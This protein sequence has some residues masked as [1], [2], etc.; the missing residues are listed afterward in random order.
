MRLTEFIKLLDSGVKRYYMTGD[1]SAGVLA[2]LDMEGRLF[3]VLNGKVV[4]RVNREAA[5]GQSTAESYLN[6]GGDTLWPAPEGTCLGYEYSSGK[7]R[8]PPA[9]TG[10]RYVV[11]RKAKNS[12]VI[13]AEIDLVNN[14]GIGLPFI[15]ERAVKVSAG[16]NSVTV[17][18]V[19]SIKYIGVKSYSKKDFMIAPW[20][21]SQF[22]SGEG[23]EAVFPGAEDT[24]IRDLYEP[25]DKVRRHAGGLWRFRTDGSAK[26]QIAIGAE[27][28]WIEFKNPAK[29]LTV[30][31]SASPV[32]G[33]M[34]YIDI[35]DAPPDTAPAKTGVRFS[36][37]SDKSCFMELEACG[38]CPDVIKP[39]AVMSVSVETKHSME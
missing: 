32:T 1:E 16:A 19:E 7:W 20:S 3:T 18:T 13:S 5:L 4:S 29:R 14:A 39:G 30:R 10:A 8:V 37:Y 21:L 31:R 26:F 15:F 23:S 34:E 24:V 25:T 11:S 6:P 2:A 12:A 35:A 22:D 17:K 36:V 38:G 33:G 9:I 27:T 28:D